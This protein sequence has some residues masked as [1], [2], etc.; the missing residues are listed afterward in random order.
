M[1]CSM[2]CIP[3][4]GQVPDGHS[5]NPEDFSMPILKHALAFSL[6]L[7]FLQQTLFAQEEEK[8]PRDS[9]VWCHL[10]NEEEPEEPAHAMQEDIH[11]ENGL[12]CVD[13]HGG[14]AGLG[15]DEDEE[16]AM[17]PAKGYIGAPEK[18]DIPRF[19]ARCH[20]DPGY[21][22]RFNPRVATDQYDRYKTSVHGQLLLRGDEKV[23]A[24]TDCHGA[25]GVLSFKDPRS[26]VY[27]LNIPATCGKCHADREYM[28]GYRVAKDVVEEYKKGVH[29]IT[30]LEKGDQ[31]APACN[32]CHGNH[33]AVPPG[34]PA[35]GFVCGQCHLNNSELFAESPHKQAFAEEELPECETCHD[36]HAI[37]HPTDAMLGTGEESI[38]VDCHEEGSDG[39]RIAEVLY[40]KIDS[41]KLR[42]SAADSLLQVARK[43]GMEVSEPLYQLNE[44]NQFLIQGRTMIHSLSEGKVDS[45][46]ARGIGLAIEAYEQGLQAI[47][48]LQFRRKGLA[49]SLVFIL[50]LA[51][52]LYLK[53]REIDSRTVFREEEVRV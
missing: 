2:I 42:L 8:Q 36:N 19:C 52:G 33:G 4:R 40:A 46:T 5:D 12:S 48:E 18:K 39:Y 30:L 34:I 23:A 26:P 9:C 16:A 35:I 13:C 50:L 53:I 37:E 11:A 7:F 47:D 32:D 20:S 27:A 14:D 25:H 24:C 21:M 29:G 41:L 28:A 15:F 1:G 45:L 17:D 31:A 44:A 51:L 49:V 43:A 10:E 6:V 3:S 38:C 22:R